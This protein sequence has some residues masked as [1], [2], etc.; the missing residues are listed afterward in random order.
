M[1]P[2]STSGST[3]SSRSG[4]SLLARIYK[5]L[6]T[7]QWALTPLLDEDSILE[8]LIA[9]QNAIE[10][11]EKWSK[12]CAAPSII[13]VLGKKMARLVFFNPEIE[14]FPGMNSIPTRFTFKCPFS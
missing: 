1:Y 3:S 9:Y 2:T 10:I 13:F 4:V 12:A 8:I 6:G 7:W 14:S 5:K 11:S